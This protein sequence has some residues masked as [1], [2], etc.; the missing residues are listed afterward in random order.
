MAGDGS[1]ATA[2]AIRKFEVFTVSQ[3]DSGVSNV[4]SLAE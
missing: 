2:N 3:L 4:S 1:L